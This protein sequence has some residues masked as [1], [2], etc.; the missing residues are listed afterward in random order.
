[1]RYCLIE[2]LVSCDTSHQHTMVT[3]CDKNIDKVKQALSLRVFQVLKEDPSNK[4]TDFFK[5][6]IIENI[7]NN[8]ITLKHKYIK[9]TT[10]TFYIQTIK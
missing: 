5:N 6:C 10:I 9:N 3:V 7:K 4:E 8:N 2:S 1:M